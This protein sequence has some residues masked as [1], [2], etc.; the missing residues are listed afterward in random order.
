MFRSLP[1]VRLIAQSAETLLC[2]I[3]VLSETVLR[4]SIENR[5]GISEKHIEREPLG[6]RRFPDQSRIPTKHDFAVVAS[7][8]GA[9][10]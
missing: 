8:L 3:D 5:G 9:S 4:L 2:N 10:S 1:P 7:I 6:E